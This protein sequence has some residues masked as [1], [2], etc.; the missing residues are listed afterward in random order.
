MTKRKWIYAGLAG[1]LGLPLLLGM[2]AFWQM[3][4]D[5]LNGV[6]SSIELSI[7]EVAHISGAQFAASDPASMIVFDTREQDE[8]AVSHLAGA[9][10]IA[11]DM[12]KEEFLAKFGHLAKGKRI[13]FYCS[14][15]ARSTQYAATVQDGLEAQ[16]AATIVNLERGLFGWH[17]EGRPL[18]NQRGEATEAIH[19]YDDYWGQL[20]E[21]EQLISKLPQ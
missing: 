1:A 6:H 8:F 17:N 19:P 5:G 12:P 7:P 2:T 18:V 10:R 13:V 14:V 11:P 9:I 3:S 16:G 4:E 20:I 15:G 21:R